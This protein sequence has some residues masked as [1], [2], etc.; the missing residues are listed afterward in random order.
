MTERIPVTTDIEISQR[1]LLRKVPVNQIA[2]GTSFPLEI[3]AENISEGRFVDLGFGSGEKTIQVSNEFAKEWEDV[4]ITGLE[5]NPQAVKALKERVNSEGLNIDT[6]CMDVTNIGFNSE[7]IDAVMACGLFCNLVGGGADRAVVELG[8]V[9]KSGGLIFLSDCLRLD[10]TLIH[11]LTKETGGLGKTVSLQ[12][13]WLRRYQENA[14]LGLP[15][16]TFVVFRPGHKDKEYDS[17]EK[18]QEHVSNPGIFERYARHWR[19]EE[20]KA[21]FVDNGFD[22]TWWQPQIFSSRTQELLLG[23]NMVF[24]KEQ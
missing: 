18:L 10:E 4:L 16:G 11:L 6:L 22:L 12:E 3:I 23:I 21:L 7:T 1:N 17:A 2:S 9:I 19:K 14:K 8:R 20:L 5:I 13:K 15:Y 24:E